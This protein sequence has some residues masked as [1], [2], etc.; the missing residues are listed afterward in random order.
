MMG[1]GPQESGGKIPNSD[2]A[3]SR[4][5][6]VMFITSQ[7]PSSTRPSIAPF[8]KRE[9]ESLIASGVDLDLFV[10]KGGWSL[11]S[12]FRATSEMRRRLNLSHYDLLHAR[13]GQCG[14]VARAQLR[15]PVVVTYGGSDVQGSPHF[16]GRYRYRSYV[17]RGISWMLSLLVDEVIVVS[18]HLGHMLPRKDY[19][20]ISCGVD[21]SL[22]RP[23]DRAEAR[24]RLGLLS[25]QRLVLFVGDPRN[26]RKRYELA[27]A[28]CEIAAASVDLRLVVLTGRPIEEVPLYMSA[29]DVLLLTSTN[30]GSP[31]VIKEALACLLPI[32][33]VD[34]GDVRERIEK[35]EGCFLCDDDDP[36]VIADGLTKVLTLGH[37]VDSSELVRDLDTNEVARRVIKI[38]RAAVSHRSA[39][40]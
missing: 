19:H 30:E 17:L 12:Y 13:F 15:V 8:V 4:R 35:L 21:L 16:S 7:W 26:K 22:F 32:V 24:S 37:L 20:V 34:V 38:Y 29:C 2:H 27:V 11:W 31:N 18:D 23:M 33:S 6:R 25:N 14:L 10:Y 28:A 5:L 40:D 1:L 9:V 36:K 3:S 39:E